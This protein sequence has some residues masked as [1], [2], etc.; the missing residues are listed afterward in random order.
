MTSRPRRH[1]TSVR[2]RLPSAILMLVVVALCIAGVIYRGAE[3]TQ[4]NVNDGGIWVTNKSKQMV[5]HLDYEA[6]ILD[7]ALRTEATNFDVGQAAETVTVS[8]LSSLTVA[9]VNVTQ[10]ALGAPTALPAG[11]IAMQ[12][13]DVLGVLNAADGT[14]WTTS[15]SSPSPSNL[16]ESA[17]LAS[18]MGAS[19]F[20][21][22]EDGS[23]YS[24]S[25]SGTLTTVKHRGSVDETKTSQVAGISEGARLS[26][27]VVGD[28]V[29]ALDAASNTLYLPGNKTLDLGAAGVESGGVLQQAGPKDDSVLL[30]TATSLVSIPLAGGRPSITPA[31]EG[32]PSGIPAAPVRHEGCAY[33]AWSGSGAYVRSCKDPSSNKQMVVDTLTSAREVVF[34]TNRKA[35]VLND[36]AEGDV[37]LP[38]SNM[39][40][41]DNWDEVENQLEESEEE[42]DS[43]ELTNEVADPQ[44]REENTPPEAVDDEFGIRPG[45]STVLPVLDNDSDLDGD[46]LTAT[47]T[48]QPGWGSVVVARSGRALQIE[49]VSADQSGSTSFTY[50]ASDGQA[51]ASARVQVTV[52]PYGQ[53]EAPVQVRSSSVKIGVGARIQ[54]QALSDW[55]DPDGDPIYL[56]DVQA[57]TGLNVSF[58][59][60]GTVTINEEGSSAGP[61]TVVLTVAD[62]QG[63]EARGELVVNVQEAGN[64]PPSA[65]GDLFQAH[66]GEAVTLDPLRNDTDPNGDPLSL[67]AVSG[68]PSGV[69]LTP[70]LDRG[71]IDFR[72]QQP[73]SY[74]FAY[75]VSD[76]IATTLGIIRVEVVAASSVRPVAENDTAVLPQGGSV[77]VNPLGNDY[78]PAG[79]M[80]SVTSVDT[81]KAPEIE[82]AL[83][84]RHLLRI[85]AHAGID[86]TVTFSYTVSNG[87][88][89]A[90][91]EVTVIPGAS[92]RSDLPP[93]LAPDRAKV[94]VGDV[95]TASVLSN[96]RSPAGLSLQVESTLEYDHASSVGTPF[97]TGNQVRLEA[98]TSPGLLEVVYSVIDSAGNRAS[99]TVTFEV[100]PDTESNEAPRPRTLNA[101]TSAGQ[102]VTIPVTLSGIDPDGDSVT[103]VGVDSSPTQG[104]A[105]AS[106]TWIDYTPNRGA[107]GTD[108]FTYTV[109][110]RKGARASARVR[111]AISPSPTSNQNPVAVPDTV[112]A[113]P[114][115]VLNIN[116]LSNDVDPD[117]DTLSLD[118]DGLTTA[119]PALNPQV[120]S[121]T[122]ISVRTPSEPGSYAV[123]YTVSDGRGGS[124]T[125]LAT[126]Y[127]SEDVPLKAPVARDDYVAYTEL[128]EDGSAVRVRVVD[129]DDDPDGSVDELKVTTGESGVNVS[130]QDLLIPVSDQL[131]LVVYTITDRD[132]LTNS[133]VVTV[134]GRNGTA[135]FL[136]NANLPIE[137]D[138]GSQRTISL[139]DY[140]IVRSGRSPQLVEGTTPVAQAGLTSVSADASSQ[141]TIA[142]AEGFSGNSA[143]TI[144]VSDGTDGGALSASLSVPVRVRATQNQPPT[145]T[146]TGVRVEAGGEPVTQNLALGVSDPEGADPSTFTYSVGTVP[147][148]ISAS[149]SGSTLTVS[150]AQDTA[151]G[152]AGSIAVSVTDTDGNSVSGS[153]PVEVVA[154]SKPAVSVSEYRTRARVNETVRVD[155]ASQAVNPFPGSPLTIEGAVLGMGSAQVRTEGT[156]VSITPDKAGTIKVTYRINDYL[157]DPSRSRQGNITVTVISKP[158]PPTNLRAEPRGTSGARLTFSVGADNG[159]TVT[160]YQVYDADTGQQVSATCKSGSCAVD[161]LSAG[162][163]YSFYVVATSSEGNSK[164]SAAS[165]RISTVGK[166]S[167]M[168]APKVEA[169]DS[170]L[171]VSWVA[172]ESDGGAAIDHYEV[173]VNGG[174]PTSYTTTS[175]TL[176]VVNGHDYAVQVRAV[177]GEGQAGP[178]SSPT[179]GSPRPSHV[180]PDEPV[181]TVTTERWEGQGVIVAKVFVS[182]KV[183]SSG[184]SGWGQTTITVNGESHNVTANE[185]QPKK[186]V[187]EDSVTTATVTVTVRN[188]EGDA[189]TST[190][191]TVRIPP[192]PNTPPFEIDPPT[193]TA[194][195][196]SGQLLFTNVNVKPGR[197]YLA[198]ELTVFWGKS[199]A[200]CAD[201]ARANDVNRKVQKGTSFVLD[202]VGTDGV[203]QAFYFC[204]ISTSGLV[205]SSIRVT[206]TPR[207]DHAAAPPP[208]DKDW[209]NIPIHAD[210]VSYPDGGFAIGI[211]RTEEIEGLCTYGCRLK[212]VGDRTGTLYAQSDAVVSPTDTPALRVEGS[213]LPVRE[214]YR[215]ALHITL[216]TRTEIIKYMH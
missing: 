202:R 198:N 54:Y 138:A 31:A 159:A 156:V 89:N 60:D 64:L 67:A 171:K 158:D 106:A 100:I 163:S 40:L 97:V 114:D 125:G 9:P 65:N 169:G 115:R 111:V 2:R 18:N 46:V 201:K 28:Q 179:K 152:Q 93:I 102:A 154:S 72:A 195:G 56:K 73:G 178:W 4:V 127:V 188:I 8:D 189:T 173:Q 194:T 130:G 128:P 63:A 208:P 182:W 136:N 146:P 92:D 61:K 122:T 87:Q 36:V 207:N 14:L 213:E 142:A 143:F 181:V 209:A 133:A 90:T 134:P 172:P 78:D 16:A 84:E 94:R 11:S 91:A 82:V 190:P 50:E 132:G 186:V 162:R 85:T 22:G 15:A 32:A 19:A 109:E 45:R 80:L 39:V 121:A 49:D 30:A 23:V 25:A 55:R 174:Q 185:P 151:R 112:Q 75:T 6:R 34:R 191:Q 135:P 216:S 79:G 153:V 70:D 118:E 116:V 157:R 148:G 77:L 214:G 42:Q 5:G 76:G 175:A 81:S 193:I 29:V 139:S 21:T 119:T 88:G 164:P 150:A 62:D 149:V 160:G 145:F 33:G 141:L 52:H 104:V 176:S 124:A 48:S 167:Q 107:V 58:V 144:Q 196:N 212:V 187:L 99:S 41:M 192:N 12:G 98:G 165:N 57:P 126:I 113:R 44:Q 137:V 1:L 47:P 155:V 117:G 166:P 17:A 140:V 103:L 38:D 53:N 147:D 24:L 197:G 105:T 69:T 120:R 183:G 66:P 215:V 129:N 204:Q 110:D 177:N 27:T 35:I 51:S 200:E 83:I 20:V 180:A 161:G 101:W 170:V 26:M 68:A 108:T 203:E 7:G 123:A 71:T 131:R 3:V 59:E 206:G 211:R 96:D 205:S 86:K 184:G 199:G 95:G 210:Y 168:V 43:P 10:V 37:W 74:S 13:G